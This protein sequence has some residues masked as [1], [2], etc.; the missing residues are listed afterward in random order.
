[1]QRSRAAYKTKKVPCAQ[2]REMIPRG[3]ELTSEGW[4][5]LWFFC[6]TSCFEELQHIRDH[7]LHGG[8][9]SGS[10]GDHQSGPDS[11]QCGTL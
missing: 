1:M 6:D 4:D 5:M 8:M 2:C 3:I 10:R 11:T 7:N 9:V